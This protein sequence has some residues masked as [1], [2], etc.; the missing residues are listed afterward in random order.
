MI[1]D[2]TKVFM[3]RYLVEAGHS[4]SQLHDILAMTQKAYLGSND[5]PVELAQAPASVIMNCMCQSVIAS[6]KARI[7]EEET[8]EIVIRQANIQSGLLPEELQSIAV[9]LKDLVI[10]ALVPLW[11]DTIV[12]AKSGRSNNG[13]P[14]GIV[15]REV[16]RWKASWSNG[17]T[18]ATGRL[19]RL[20]EYPNSTNAPSLE[21]FA[22]LRDLSEQLLV[23]IE[24]GDRRLSRLLNRLVNAKLLSSDEESKILLDMGNGLRDIL[25]IAAAIPEIRLKRV[26]TSFEA[27][28]WNTTG[29]YRISIS[30]VTGGEDSKK[31]STYATSNRA[32]A[33][34]EVTLEPNL[35][36]KIN[37]FLSKTS[38]SMNLEKDQWEGLSASAQTMLSEVESGSQLKRADASIRA[39]VQTLLRDLTMACAAQ[40]MKNRAG[41]SR[42]RASSSDISIRP[43]T[44]P[45]TIASLCE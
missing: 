28:S 3:R 38:D 11:K 20:A 32:T 43:P 39:D 34:T 15:L 22:H 18:V 29:F 26:S 21:D 14:R 45:I 17:P 25:G 36:E 24:T 12:D 7:R 31:R 4:L 6:L 23:S 2:K 27:D 40:A 13:E 9:S 42:K 19:Q 30:D 1:N 10:P 8:V 44:R 41:S 33:M 37:H 35:H 5:D 16:K